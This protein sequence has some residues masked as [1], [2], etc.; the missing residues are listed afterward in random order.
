MRL[1]PVR[2]QLVLGLGALPLA[3]L[4]FGPGKA[5]WAVENRV[6]M[7]EENGYR[8]ITSNGIPDHPTGH[9]PNRGNPNAIS[10]Q[11]LTF[12]MPLV[13]RQTGRFRSVQGLRAGV[14]VNG[15][16]F[17]PFTAEFWNRDR[18]WNYDALSGPK[19]LGL[20]DNQAHV[21]PTGLYHYHGWPKGLIRSWSQETHSP[22][23]GWAAD[24]FPIYAGY[25]YRDPNNPDGGLAWLRSG[26]RIRDG[27]RTGG[28][29][30]RHDGSFFADW[31]W[32]KGLGDVDQANGRFGVT[33][34]FPQG[35]YAYFLTREWPI[36][37]RYLAG[38]PDDSFRI[39]PPAGGRGGPPG[40][41]GGGMGMR[42]PPPG[43]GLGM[44]PPGGRRPPPPG[45]RRPD[46]F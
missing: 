45:F 36:V 27:E 7:V 30:G 43:G 14:A 11:S 12:R 42:P 20:D 44:E 33:P 16:P 1:D 4:A 25:A 39:G 32:V 46:G 6:S 21:Q 22:I 5:A 35:T 28:P 19:D 34:E 15:V 37:P 8:V 9:F 17:D 38:T 18:A 40:A 41:P 24:G 10:A 13:P 29:G 23:V 31:E 26:W 3:V 2:R